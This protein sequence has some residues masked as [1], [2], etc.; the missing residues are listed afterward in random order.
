M[1]YSIR[2]VWLF[3]SKD[4]GDQVADW[5]Y[6]IANMSPCLRR[7][8]ADMSPINRRLV[9]N[10]SPTSIIKYNLYPNMDIKWLHKSHRSPVSC[11]EISRKQV[12]NRSRSRCKQGFSACSKDS[13]RLISIGDWLATSRK[14]F[15]DL[16]NGSVISVFF[17]LQTSHEQVAESV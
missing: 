10:L 2:Y 12:A 11:K 9:V 15:R 13:S 5:F 3:A 8:V 7:P 6:L 4:S 17:K 16:C 14:P 1:T